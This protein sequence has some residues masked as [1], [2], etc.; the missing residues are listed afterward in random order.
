MTR[1]P[2]RLYLCPALLFLA[3]AGCADDDNTKSADPPVTQDAA[4]TQDAAQSGDGALRTTVIDD[5]EDGDGTPL[6]GTGGWYMHGDENPDSEQTGKSTVGVPGVPGA[7]LNVMNGEG[8]NGSKKSLQVEFTFDQNNLTYAPFIGFGVTLGTASKPIDLSSYESLSYTYKGPAHIVRIEVTEVTDF[9]EF[10]HSEPASTEW[11]TVTIPFSAFAQEGWGA[12]ATFN[13]AH[14]KNISFQVRGETGQTGTMLVDDMQLLGTASDKPAPQPDMTID[15]VS[16]PAKTAIDSVAIAN[17][18]Q[19]KAAK[20]LTRGYN[21]TNWLEQSAFKSFGT[22][23]E[24]YVANLAK[25]GF[26]ALRLPIDLDMYAEKTGTKFTLPVVVKADL[27][28]VL[29]SFNEWTKSHG[30]SL[31]ID[32]H[33]YDRTLS[34]KDADS[35]EVAAQMWGKVAE[36][37]AS[38]P[39]EDLFYELLNE[40]E[41]SFST[42]AQPKVADWTTLSGNMITAIRA[43]DKTHTLLFGDVGFYGIGQLSKRTPLADD[44]VI[45]VVHFYGPFLFTHQGASW[46]DLSSAHDIPWP[47]SPERWSQYY[48][49]FGLS[50]DKTPSWLIN[51]AN[52]YSSMGTKE[53]LWNSLVI[54]KKW[55]V[56]NNV[57]VICNEFGVYERSSREE[58]RVR[59]YTD[60]ISVFEELEMPWQIWF[61]IMSK[62]GAVLPAYTTAF[63]L[64]T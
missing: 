43:F 1:L 7:E 11:R 49:D 27:W 24:T 9:D 37:F 36:H 18:L 22:Y 50:I 46:A 47:Y 2:L 38:E 3:A 53:S 28:T 5:F 62:T 41:L 35:L 4:A 31:T 55:A 34:T 40:P 61:M 51:Q 30:M 56:Q 33:S 45:Y 10:G 6:L 29:D 26:K 39:R 32:Y 25:N 57:P 64:G 54:A 42:S 12:A 63:K 13:P 60:L 48:S 14:V 58:D 52:M 23:D 16:P 17:P 59:Y 20:Y 19:A 15:P 8:A 21:I 44:N